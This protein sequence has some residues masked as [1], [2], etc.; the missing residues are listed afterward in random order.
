MYFVDLNIF[1]GRP[2]IKAPSNIDASTAQSASVDGYF[3]TVPQAL[4]DTQA[5]RIEAIESRVAE[6]PHM[7]R[8]AMQ[9][10][11]LFDKCASAFSSVSILTCVL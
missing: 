5:E 8:Q 7:H 4:M 2:I 6:L 10:Y 11:K 9:A 1:I 3:G